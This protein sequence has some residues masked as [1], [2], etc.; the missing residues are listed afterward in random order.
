LL[1]LDDISE[2]LDDNRLRS[3]LRWLNDNTQSQIF[4]SDTDL[5]KTPR[6]LAEVE[7]EFET[8]SLQNNFIL[9]EET[10]QP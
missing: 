5:E 2:K 9:P 3:L 7:M 10:H 4:L 8:I 6:L 1:I